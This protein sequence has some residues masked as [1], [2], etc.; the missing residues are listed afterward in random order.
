MPIR[1]SLRKYLVYATLFISIF[2]VLPIGISMCEEGI[3]VERQKS[4]LIEKDVFAIYLSS[5]V[6]NISVQC[7]PLRQSGAFDLSISTSYLDY[8]LGKVSAVWVQ[9][10]EPGIYN[11]TVNF[12]SNRS[13]EYV[14]GVYTRNFDFYKE[15]YGKRISIRDYF[16]EL[17]P[18]L[19][20]YPGNW[21]IN[22]ILT[23]YNLSPS[24]YYIT[25][26]SPVNSAI[27]IAAVGLIAYINSFVFLDTYF[28]S[29]KEIVSYT[30]WIIVGI[31]ILISAY[32]AYQL[33]KFT[34]FSLS[35]GG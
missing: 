5:H 17:Q 15:Y 7:R 4:I 30:R 23:V 31:V 33:Y 1:S 19:T 3:N 32:A 20:R 11:L 16:V 34:V 14:L 29:K 18:T 12:V 13:W 26:P 9:L 28:K 21:T 35:G 2:Q 24:F 6:E 8:Y 25:L 27:L 10:R 22:V